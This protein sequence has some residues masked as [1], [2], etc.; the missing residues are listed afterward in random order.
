MRSFADLHLRTNNKDLQQLAILASKTSE[1]GYRIASTP[2]PIETN[3][4]EIQRIRKIFNDFG[5]DYASRVD[6]R[7]RNPEDLLNLL[8]KTR[9]RFE[10]ISVIIEKK[11]IAR[12]AAKD[13]RVDLLSFPLLDY[14]DRFFDRAEAELASCGSAGLEVD[15]R[16]IMVLDGAP[17]IRFL[18]TLRREIA[19]ASEF[20]VP[21]ILSSGVSEEQLLRKPKE[22]AVLSS[23][24]GLLG[25]KALDAVSTSPANLVK[26]NRAK[27]EVGFVAPGIRV[28]KQ[29]EKP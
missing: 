7:P 3:L 4:E 26:K 18:S 2:I 28:V 27:L 21:I 5:L 16:P 29:G 13:H 23:L 15:M 6:L 11:E 14:R 25:D 12:Q 8:R 19:T 24:F 1:L 20:H 22:M 17:R 9:R 10:I